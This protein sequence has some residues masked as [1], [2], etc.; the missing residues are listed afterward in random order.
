MKSPA[1]WVNLLIG[2]SLLMAAGATNEVSVSPK[3]LPRVPPTEATNALRNFRIKAGFR[4]ELA[5]AEPLVVSP[6][7]MSF[8]ENGRL[9]VVEM[10]DYSERRPEQLGRIRLLEDTNGDGRFDKSTVFADHL[11]W[12]TAVICYDG[13]VF[14]GATPDIL[15]LKDTDGDGVADVRRQVFTGFASD[16]APYETNKLNVQAMLNSFNW[17]LDNRIHGATSLSGGKVTS[18]ENPTAP[19]DLRGR[20]FSFDPKTLTLTAEAGGA[21]H[22]LSFDDTGR[23]FLCSN[24]D[25]IQTLM[26]DDRYAARNP[27]YAMP[28][29]RVSIAADGPAAEV[30]R[31]SPD[32]PWRVIR[33]KWR[34]T[35][36]VPGLIEGGGRPSGYFTAATG[37]T[38]YRGNAWPTEYLG[39][40]FIADC[41]SNLA[42]RKKLYPDDVG[43]LAK[44]PPGEER[45]EF[46]AS[47]DNWFRPVQFANAPDGS[48]YVIDMYREVIEHPWSLPEPL[49][50]HLDLNSGNDRGRIYRIVPLNFKQPK[51]PQLGKATTTQLVAT[52]AHPN[53]WH[54][55]TAARLLYERQDKTAVPLLTRLLNDSKFPLGRMHALHALDG[56]HAL[57]EAHVLRGLRDADPRVREHAVLLS[58]KLISNNGVIAEAIWNQLRMLTADPALRVRYQLAFTL[59]E[60][61]HAGRVAVLAQVL[62]SDLPSKWMQA[63]VMSSLAEGTG[64]MFVTLASDP[65]LRNAPVGQE[66]LSQLATVVGAKN[67]PEEVNAVLNFI[68][69]LNEQQPRFTFTR[70]LGDGLLRGHSSLTAADRQGKLKS[71]YSEAVVVAA[72]LRIPEPLRLQAIRL[73]GSTSYNEVGDTLIRLLDPIQSQAVQSSALTTLTSFSD[74]RIGHTLAQRWPNLTPALRN[75]ALTALLARPER[76][77]ALLTA[78]EQGTIRPADLSP[79]QTKFL[80]SYRDQSIQKRA[81]KILA[82][83]PTRAR[84]EV[85]NNFMPALQ[86]KGNAAAGREI[87]LARCATCH[88]LEGAGFALGP[89]LT[90]VKSSGKETMLINILDP[91]REVLPNYISYVIETKTGDSLIG[92]I[93]NETA[94]SVT[95]KQAGGV[96]SVVLRSNI[97]SIQSQGQSTMP[98]GLE[99]GLTAQD[100]ANLLEFIAT[101]GPSK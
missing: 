9:F 1:V 66:F 49:K 80:K 32:E 99:A 53:G 65:V 91:N 63:A 67:Q 33:T 41:G 5:A 43:L 62:R 37:T 101:A 6:V 83:P 27:Y 25:H 98:E 52:L 30:Y 82:E 100:L 72:N 81:V 54:R 86:L 69:G 93:A 39:D 64:E 24:S 97:Q 7:A 34:V 51:L 29:S 78:I 31:I 92:L 2:P 4:L 68:A 11:P 36:V 87:F 44:R 85:V 59:G 3:D 13:G 48:L 40:A 10:I 94:T 28:G 61:K 55:D 50:I 58:E 18:V 70:A 75:Q 12:P 76:V 88:R 74:P 56:L 96:E 79:N 15:F 14:V 35:G 21:Q 57:T 45:V 19:I 47:T 20:D 26:Y 95:L 73:L 71:L 77:P 90:S 89:D 84:Q 38:I 46:L 42:H 23:K 16:Y 8:D 22:G 60:F 17:G